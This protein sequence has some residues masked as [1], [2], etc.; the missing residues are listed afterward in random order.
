[1]TP[2]QRQYLEILAKRTALTGSEQRRVDEALA[3]S[4]TVTEA[5]AL[6]DELKAK[7]RSG[8]MHYLRRPPTR[9]HR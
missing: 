2:K 6:I 9:I 3:G 8:G 1:M 4:L 7:P 5:S